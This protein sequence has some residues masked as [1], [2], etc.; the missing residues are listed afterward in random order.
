M[1]Q[2]KFIFSHRKTFV[3]LIFKNGKLTF[4]DRLATFFTWCK[5]LFFILC[6]AGQRN[7]FKLEDCESFIFWILEGVV[8]IRDHAVLYW[9]L[10]NYELVL[11]HCGV[12]VVVV[13]N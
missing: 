10:K 9:G 8:L 5:T 4:K 13:T 2:S 3:K 6:N 12:V 11:I 7:L 1:K